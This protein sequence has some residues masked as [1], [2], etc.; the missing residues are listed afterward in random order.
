MECC[1]CKTGHF[2]RMK[3]NYVTTLKTGLSVTVPNLCVDLC[4]T[5]GEILFDGKAGRD[6]EKAVVQVVPYWYRE[7]NAKARAYAR[8]LRKEAAGLKRLPKIVGS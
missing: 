4:D 1:S 6:I 5:C 3:I 7:G 8:K 2:R